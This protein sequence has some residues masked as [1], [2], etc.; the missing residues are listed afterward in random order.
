MYTSNIKINKCLKFYKE[1][2]FE[3]ERLIKENFPPSER[4][5]DFEIRAEFT[6][7]VLYKHSLQELFEES[8]PPNNDKLSFRII[9]W[10]NDRRIDKKIEVRLYGIVRDVEIQGENEVW[11][12]G[13]HEMLKDF[14]LRRK[15][16]YSGIKSTSSVIAGGI[17][18]LCLAL[19]P[20]TFKAAHYFIT[21]ILIV[22]AML[23]LIISYPKNNNKL[24]PYV[25]INYFSKD[26][27]KYDIAAINSL[28][29][30]V[31]GGLTLIATIIIGIL[32]LK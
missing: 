14:F 20:S 10:S 29:G 9:G 15:T 21:S 31:I 19:V 23:A 28:I 26:E 7:R 11:V 22:M 27:K 1:D 18:G 30:T 13:M 32:T 12:K 2:L 24:F 4:R 25:R 8:P 6:N 16:F 5:E 3:L 17:L